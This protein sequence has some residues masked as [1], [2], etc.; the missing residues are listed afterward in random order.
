MVWRP[1]KLSS[2]LRTVYA[3]EFVITRLRKK[4]NRLAFFRSFFFHFKCLLLLNFVLIS[5]TATIFLNLHLLHH[6]CSHITNPL[7]MC[8]GT[9][10]N[11]CVL[12]RQYKTESLCM[13][14]TQLCLTFWDP[15]DYSLPD[16]SVHGTLQAR[17]LEWFA[18]S[19]SNCFVLKR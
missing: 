1:Q 4:C 16:S 14:V 12:K 13:L 5:K 8:A 19:F 15:M 2:L 17:I 6:L 11:C 9:Y 7:Q 10:T 3:S 18:I